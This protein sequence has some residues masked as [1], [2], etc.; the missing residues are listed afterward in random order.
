[1]RQVTIDFVTVRPDGSYCMRVL[2]EG[3][4]EGEPLGELRRIQERL[5][6]VIEVVTTGKFV[7][8]Y[9]ES[10]GRQVYIKLDCYRVPKDH[11]CP[12]FDRFVAA[13]QGSPEWAPACETIVFEIH[14]L[15][16]EEANQPPQRNAGSR[17]SSDDSP[18]SETP[19]SLGPRG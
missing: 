1:M 13:I 4:W 2:E 10:K 12:F 8:R 5:Y 18:A 19:A 7:E 11:I 15:G 9:P 17:P 6:D 14:H 3:P 16:E